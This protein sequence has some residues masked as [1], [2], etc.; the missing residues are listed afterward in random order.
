MYECQWKEKVS[1][2]TFYQIFNLPFTVDPNCLPICCNILGSLIKVDPVYL[3]KWYLKL[4]LLA[5]DMV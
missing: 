2:P 5:M 1:D 4:Q 3:H